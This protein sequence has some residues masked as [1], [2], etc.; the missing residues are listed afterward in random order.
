MQSVSGA[1]LPT[2]V[3]TLFG[4]VALLIPG[5]ALADEGASPHHGGEA[6]LILPD[7]GSV[8][9]LGMS[10]RS[11][12]MF[13]LLVAAAG[14][15]FGLMVLNQVKNLPAHRSMT[16]VSQLIWETCKTYLI[17]QG[18][19]IMYLEALVGAIIV[20]YFGLLQQL[21][22]LKVLVILGFSVI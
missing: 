3:S 8:Q 21:G 17:T 22:V 11:L 5:L 9:V 14:I 12:L 19:F 4:L 2:F 18:K 10:G 15:G 1:R 16:E 13:G 20:V 7:L 6:S